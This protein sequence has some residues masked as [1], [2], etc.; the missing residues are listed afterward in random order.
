MRLP[1]AIK[2]AVVVATMAPLLAFGLPGVFML[3]VSF[4]F[5]DQVAALFDART[6]ETVGWA[7]ILAL[8]SALAL[9]H[10]SL[11]IFYL[12]HMAKNHSLPVSIRIILL[13][14]L[15]LLP[16]VAMPVYCVLYVLPDRPTTPGSSPH[17]IPSSQ[18]ARP[19][20]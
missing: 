10:V 13:P 1:H 17:T 19:D 2:I 8:G 11:T 5:W 3:A 6:A 15:L 14:A 20:P 4:G 7:V 9:L 18:T 16:L 12:W